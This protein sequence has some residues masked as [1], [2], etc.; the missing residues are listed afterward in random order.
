MKTLLLL[1]HAKSSWDDKA[2]SD[3]ERP[4]EARGERDAEKM[5]KR[6][7]QRQARPDLIVSSPALRALEAAPPPP[8]RSPP[9]AK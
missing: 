7:S 2:L 1:R 9:A 5:G 6:L 4:L 8:P 3:L